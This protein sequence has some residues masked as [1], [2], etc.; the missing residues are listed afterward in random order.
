LGNIAVLGAQW[1]D[2]GKGKVV[3]LLSRDVDIVARYQG[4]ANAGHTVIRG[5]RQF[6]FHLIPSGILNPRLT[7]VIGNG[8]VVDPASLRGEIARL[9][10]HG[11]RTE[12]RLFVSTSAHAT[13]P[14]HRLLDSAREKQ[15]GA[16]RI[17][18]TQRGIGPTYADKAA[19]VGIRL[20][21]LGDRDLLRD[22][23]ERNLREK[24]CLLQA[25]SHR[26][27]LSLEPLLREYLS[28]GS[29]LASYLTDTSALLNAALER[30]KRVLFEGAQGALLDIDHGTY[31]YVT[32]S[33]AGAGGICSGL[34]I[35]PQHLHSILGVA[36]AYATRVGAGPFPTELPADLDET[37]RIRGRE[38]GATTGRPR[39]CGWFDAVAVRHA[40]RTSG[41]EA[42]A[43]T[44]LDV[45][46]GLAAVKV[47]VG[48]RLLPPPGSS[49]RSFFPRA[50]KGQWTKLNDFPT[51]SG[52]LASCEPIYEEIPGWPGSTRGARSWRQLPIRARRY[53]ERLSDLTGVKIAMVS[54]GPRPSETIRRT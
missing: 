38:Y 6:V 2:E 40:I 20:G 24:R 14:Y 23:L 45:L 11:V 36:K 17:G 50:G 43:I 52:L 12:G 4:G 39:R 3:D 21:D 19:R 41:I 54:V 7:C 49:H 31:P 53:L 30:G 37:I 51:R 28:H 22:L 34:G 33:N 18:T 8:V 35:G 47:C 5:K 29:R 44:K 1:G 13:L 32:S 25:L 9:H 27:R 26:R 48:Y 46:D 16:G 15:L 42:L 10:A